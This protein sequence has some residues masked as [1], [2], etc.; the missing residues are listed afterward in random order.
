MVHRETNSL[1]RL[2]GTPR[3]LLSKADGDLAR[4]TDALARGR[5][6]EALHALMDCSITVF[7]TGDWIRATHTDHRRS[8]SDLA[9]NSKWL[10]M[11]RDIANVAK[12]GDLTWKAVDAK[13]H[14]AVLAKLEYKVDRRKP[15]TDHRIVGLATDATSH[16]VVDVLREAIVE[17]RAFVEAKGI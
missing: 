8:S 12:H 11:T 5:Q 4:L 1:L 7:H 14:G 10:R 13:T 17:W 2:F 6:R 16:D 9:A 3:E 15:A